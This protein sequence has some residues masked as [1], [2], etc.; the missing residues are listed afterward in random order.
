MTTTN[1]IPKHDENVRVVWMSIGLPGSGKSTFAK[2]L[3]SSDPNRWK[4]VNRDDVRVA[5]TGTLFEVGNSRK[6][7]LVTKCCDAMIRE[8]L[9]AGFD[10][11]VDNTHL[12]SSDRKSI[13]DIASN[14]DNTLV[15]EQVFEVPLERVHSQNENRDPKAVV[16][17]IVIERMAKDARVGHDGTFKKLKGNSTYYEKIE[18]IIQDPSKYP[19]VICDLDGTLALIEHRN[20][21]DAS[22]CELDSLNEPVAAIIREQVKVAKI[23]FMSGR[24][25][26][27][28]IQTRSFIDK[29]LPELKD[30]YNLY[31]RRDG[32]MRKDSIVKKELFDANIKNKYYVKFCIDDR[33]SLVALW[34]SLGLT[35][36]QCNYGDF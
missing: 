18:P 25:D 9:N 19:C 12:K 17:R 34:R 13:H 1:M 36:F 4:R 35:C 6:E 24:S 15:I 16:P 3:L 7:S 28:E 8:A 14:R 21:Y 2:N 10:V 20:P 30:Q 26:K 11:L 27:Y 23:V 31:M 32:D 5:L 33:D 29:N 22:K